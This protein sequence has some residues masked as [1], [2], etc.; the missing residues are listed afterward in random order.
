MP[1]TTAT[2]K[3]THDI[4][5]LVDSLDHLT[6]TGTGMVAADKK[7][8]SRRDERRRA[9][10]N[11]VERRRRDKINSWI[12]KLGS[13]IPDTC[14]S[15]PH[16]KHPVDGLSKGGILAAACEY[17][18]ELKEANENLTK[19]KQ[20]VA[21]LFETSQFLVEEN[22]RLQQENQELRQ[23]LLRHGLHYEPQQIQPKVE[24]EHQP[25]TNPL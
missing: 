7:P 10:H 18:G 8:S 21:S 13:I 5:Q 6:N 1:I 12:M 4:H 23:I 22:N 3:A 14:D 25:L 24:A 15:S 9:T 16:S 11:E 17:I 19:H 2:T 20:E